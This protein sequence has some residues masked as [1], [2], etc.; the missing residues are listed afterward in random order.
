MREYDDV[1]AMGVDACGRPVVFEWRGRR[2]RVTQV[3][4]TW[5]ER[6]PWWRDPARP[7]TPDE[8][9]AP[10]FERRLEQRTWRVEATA[11]RRASSGVFHLVHHGERWS[12]RALTD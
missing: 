8:Q 1:V 3:L 9:G 11:G 4:D 5:R 10:D 2:Y 6:V 12:L 7:T